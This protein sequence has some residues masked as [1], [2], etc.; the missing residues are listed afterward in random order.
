[1]DEQDTQTLH[2]CDLDPPCPSEDTN[3]RE[4]QDSALRGD[5]APHPPWV[6]LG[7]C[8]PSCCCPGL[9]K[10]SW[11]QSLGVLSLRDLLL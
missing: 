1:M 9:C 2:C 10:A 6:A 7:P 4:L 5:A 3:S 8:S 11:A